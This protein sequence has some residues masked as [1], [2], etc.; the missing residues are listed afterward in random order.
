MPPSALAGGSCPQNGV[1]ELAPGDDPVRPHRQDAQHSL[2]SGLTH[3]QFPVVIP[4]RN[5]TK[6]ADA[7]H[8]CLADLPLA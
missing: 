2:L 5:G 6:D 8:H 4:G 7:Q 1:D 3:R